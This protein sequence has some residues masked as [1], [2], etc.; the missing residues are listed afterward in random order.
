MEQKNRMAGRSAARWFSRLA[1]ALAVG[2]TVLTVRTCCPDA[3][4]TARSWLGFGEEGKAQAAFSVLRDS[5]SQGSGV[6]AAFAESYQTL[7]G[8]TP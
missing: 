1:L 3:V 4:Q 7:T 6:A 2:I 5:L 8:E